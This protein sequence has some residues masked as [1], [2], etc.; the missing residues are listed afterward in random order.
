VISRTGKWLTEWLAE[1]PQQQRV[2]PSP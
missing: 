1:L 2:G